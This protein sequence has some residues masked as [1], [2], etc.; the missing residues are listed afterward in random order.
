MRKTPKNDTMS[1]FDLKSRIDPQGE[2]PSYKILLEKYEAKK[3]ILRRLERI[4]NS[5]NPR[6]D[7]TEKCLCYDR[8]KELEQ[9]LGHNG[10]VALEIMEKLMK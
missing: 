5:N 7:I 2:T 3:R 1:I 6:M 10:L 8:I 4:E 9:G